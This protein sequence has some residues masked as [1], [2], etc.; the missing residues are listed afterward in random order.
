[1]LFNNARQAV[2]AARAEDEETY[3]PIDVLAWTTLDML[4]DGNLD[5]Q[6]RADIIAEVL[7]AFELIDSLELD[8]D[9]LVLY[10]QRRQQFGDIA[11]NIEVADAAFEALAS[12]G[13]G[14]GVYLRARQIANMSAGQDTSSC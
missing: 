5:D 4:R 14:A 13:S 6:Q 2:L 9:E 8:S 12:Q 10:H 3:Y 7:A 1:M 11:G